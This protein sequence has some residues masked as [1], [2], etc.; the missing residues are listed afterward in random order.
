[1]KGKIGRI[2]KHFVKISH[3]KFHSTATTVILLAIVALAGVFT[4]VSAQA[5]LD[6]VCRDE[7]LL[8]G[9]HPDDC[10]R[11]FVCMLNRP[12]VFQ[13]PE[14]RIY[15]EEMRACIYGNVENCEA[16]VY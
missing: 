4:A 12:I 7:M 6:A 13:C 14:G 3:Q 8:F 9:I 1:M 11:H 16:E 10:T 5:D 15:V 2:R